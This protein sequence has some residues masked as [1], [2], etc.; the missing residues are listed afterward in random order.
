ME[1]KRSLKIDSKKPKPPD[2][3]PALLELEAVTEFAR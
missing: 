3:D 1:W 2:L